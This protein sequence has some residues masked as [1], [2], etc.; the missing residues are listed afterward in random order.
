M[1]TGSQGQPMIEGSNVVITTLPARG[2][3]QGNL[4]AYRLS[5]GNQQWATTLPAVSLGKAITPKI[6]ADEASSL[7]CFDPE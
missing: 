4:V 7:P 6:I 1:V 3:Q 5:D 2:G